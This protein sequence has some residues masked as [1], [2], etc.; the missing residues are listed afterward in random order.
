MIGKASYALQC[1][2]CIQTLRLEEMLLLFASQRINIQKLS[3]L[4]S[5]S[6]SRQARL[7]IFFELPVEQ[8]PFLDS[9]NRFLYSIPD[10][11][12][13]LQAASSS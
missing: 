8:T 6:A 3:L 2:G 13:L 5:L 9:L 11:Q 12:P 7:E 4:P 10:C 1:S